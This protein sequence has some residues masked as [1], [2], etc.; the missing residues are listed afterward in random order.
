MRILI[1]VAV[2]FITA[3]SFSSC[4]K[5]YFKPPVIDTS[6]PVSFSAVIEPM[7]Q[8]QCATAGCHSGA[9]APNLVTGKCY[10]ALLDGGYIDIPDTLNIN[11]DNTILFQRVDK[12][13]P[14]PSGLPPAELEQVRAWIMQGAKNN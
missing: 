11:P 4:E 10:N 3:L 7:F 14:K 1:F 5:K 8:T 12:D 6:V 2:C 9:V 13:M